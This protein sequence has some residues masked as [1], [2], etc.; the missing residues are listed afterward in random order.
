M[1]VCQVEQL[2][3][4]HQQLQRLQLEQTR[5]HG[6][7]DPKHLPPIQTLPIVVPATVMEEPMQKRYVLNS[8][9]SKNLLI[10]VH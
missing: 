6:K 3:Q 7:V 1:C 10:T 9:T 5:L 2:R 8:L 4:Q